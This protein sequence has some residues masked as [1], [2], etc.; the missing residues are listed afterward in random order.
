MKTEAVELLKAT[1][2]QSFWNGFHSITDP[3]DGLVYTKASTQSVDTY[4]RLGA[5]ETPEQ[6]E[7]DRDA[8]SVPELTYT[9]TN[10]PWDRTVRI[11]KRMIKYQQWD[12]ISNLVSNLGMKAAA[13]RP[14]KMTALLEAGDSTAGDDGQNFFD[15]DHADPGA[16][17]TTSQDNDLSQAPVDADAPTDLEC[18]AAVRAMFNALFGFKDSAGDPFVDPGDDAN[19]FVLMVPT[20]LRA[21]FR[22]VLLADSLTG[23]LGNDVRGSFNLRVNQFATVSA[24]PEFFLLY[25]GS[26]HKPVI[27]SESGGIMTEDMYDYHSGDYF[28]SASWWG[29][30]AYG[31]WRT[32][33]RMGWADA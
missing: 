21:Q 31:Q 33:V 32:A 12:E 6:W 2:V 9:V 22:R 19:N 10:K 17:Y 28:Y 13:H 11:S 25:A 18:A 7:G 23:P 15:T 5:A 8:K 27:L 14:K 24:S 1:A 30:T 26:P 29:E 4:T 16:V 20:N 3:F